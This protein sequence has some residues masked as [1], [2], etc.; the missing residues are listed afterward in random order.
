MVGEGIGVEGKS[1]GGGSEEQKRQKLP[2]S[3][4]SL[5][6]IKGPLIGCRFGTTETNTSAHTGRS[7]TPAAFPAFG[8]LH[9]LRVY[10]RQ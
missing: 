3:G 2:Q 7:Q 4:Q 8:P 6:E 5:I 9:V 10:K 1:V